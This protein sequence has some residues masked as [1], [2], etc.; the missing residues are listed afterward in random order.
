ML[1]LQGPKGLALPVVVV[2]FASGCDLHAV[3]GSPL[4]RVSGGEE[5]VS[6]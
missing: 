2:G 1:Q 4:S 3:S 6:V 5:E